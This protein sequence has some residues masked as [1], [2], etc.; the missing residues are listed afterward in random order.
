MTTAQQALQHFTKRSPNA[1]KK[2]KNWLNTPNKKPVI[3]LVMNHTTTTYE[4][5]TTQQIQH[6][7]QTTEHALGTTNTQQAH[8]TTPI[9]DWNPNYAFIHTLHHITETIKHLPTWQEFKHIAQTHPTIKPMLWE[10][11]QHAIHT[12]TQH[13]YTPQQAQNAMRHRIGNA[14]YS[15]LREAYVHATLREHNIHTHYHPLADALF[16]VDLYTNTTN[17]NLYIGNKTYKNNNTG[18]K[19]SSQQLLQDA[20]PPFKTINLQLQTQHPYGNVH[21]PTPHTILTTIQNTLTQ[22]GPQ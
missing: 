2:Y 7:A 8:Q 14:Y 13:G 6:I 22:K 11:A 3:Q 5:L 21:L 10:P 17:I 12:A 9:R 4:N 16:R 15:F 18:R 1:H 19:T 20:N